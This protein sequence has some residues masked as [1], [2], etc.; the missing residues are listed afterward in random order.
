MIWYHIDNIPPETKVYVPLSKNC[1]NMIN[2]GILSHGKCDTDV[3]VMHVTKAGRFCLH[4]LLYPNC[5][6]METWKT[7]KVWHEENKYSVI[8]IPEKL[9]FL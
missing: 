1:Y 7:K 6:N 2:P 3:D 8:N 4:N 5:E 9:H